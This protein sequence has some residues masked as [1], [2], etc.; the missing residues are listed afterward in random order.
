[1]YH[2]PDSM[3][4]LSMAVAVVTGLVFAY[5]A[6][7]P[8]WLLFPMKKNFW[9][10]VSLAI[11]AVSISG[12]IYCVIRDAEWYGDHTV[13]F[14]GALCWVVWAAVVHC[15]GLLWCACDTR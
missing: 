11:Y 3:I 5:V 13:E 14:C 4:P 7:R 12:I 15:D 8:S 10:V 1:M 6:A 2:A 9:L